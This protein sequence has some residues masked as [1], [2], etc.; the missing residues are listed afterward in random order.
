MKKRKAETCVWELKDG[1]YHPSCSSPKA[2]RYVVV[3]C[4]T[5]SKKVEV[6]K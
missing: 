1:F 3:F 6:K 4:P 5:C 2:Y